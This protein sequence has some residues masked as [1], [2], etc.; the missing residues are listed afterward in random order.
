M[1]VLNLRISESTRHCKLLWV[2]RRAVRPIVSGGRWQHKLKAKPTLPDCGMQYLDAPCSLILAAGSTRTRHRCCNRVWRGC[3]A[4]V[5]CRLGNQCQAALCREAVQE[6]GRRGNAACC[7][8]EFAFSHTYCHTIS[9]FSRFLC[10]IE[11]SSCHNSLHSLKYLGTQR[12][13]G[14]GTTFES[15]EGGIA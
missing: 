15:V 8:C 10:E 4:D 6:G 14:L 5:E 7:A 2:V 9:D 13:E 3:Q 11:P 12:R 1:P